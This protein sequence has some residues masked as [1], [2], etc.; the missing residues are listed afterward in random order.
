LIL[1]TPPTKNWQ[2]NALTAVYISFVQYKLKSKNQCKIEEKYPKFL[3]YFEQP[4]NSDQSPRLWIEIDL[5]KEI[6]SDWSKNER[7]FL[8]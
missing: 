1:S 8:F 2:K 4:H 3:C 5:T 7:S 6:L